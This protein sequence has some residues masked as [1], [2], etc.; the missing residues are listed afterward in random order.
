[1]EKIYLNGVEVEINKKEVSN[2]LERIVYPIAIIDFE[3]FRTLNSRYKLF[4]PAENDFQEKIFSVSTLIFTRQE[5][6]T[7]K[8]LHNKKLKLFSKTQLSSSKDFPNFDSLLEYQ[9]V[10]FKYFISKLLKYHVK[11]LI[12]LGSRT[13]I[14]LLKNYLAY[15]F[16]EPKY[17]NKISYFFNSKTIFDLYDLWNRDEMINLPAQKFNKKNQVG[18]TKK[19]MILI[20]NNDQYWNILQKINSDNSLIRTKNNNQI[21]SN[22]DIGRIV[23]QYYSNNCALLDN[24]LP[25]VTQ[26]NEYDVLMGATILSVLYTIM[27]KTKKKNN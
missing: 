24:F 14:T 7:I 27:E 25:L 5:H 10:F 8:N 13:E 6:L 21:I 12:F 20:K 1:M 19:S 23:D 22:N 26:H 2:F 9:M 17:K 18:A 11:S 16:D 3:T 4:S 15:F